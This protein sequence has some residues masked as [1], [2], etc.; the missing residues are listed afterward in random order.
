[1]SPWKT[2]DKPLHASGQLAASTTAKGSL[3]MSPSNKKVESLKM[4][5]N[6]SFGT[7]GVAGR[8]SGVGVGTKKF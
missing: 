4:N 8:N 7:F 5:S 2:Q 3:H 6:D 1:M